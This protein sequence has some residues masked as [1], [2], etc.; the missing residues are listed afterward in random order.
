MSVSVFFNYELNEIFLFI[1][2]EVIIWFKVVEYCNDSEKKK[3]L[4]F[5]LRFFDVIKKFNYI[6]N[7]INIY[8]RCIY[9]II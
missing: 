8:N 4:V 6:I 5:V 7:Y 3:I 9:M 2:N 1:Y